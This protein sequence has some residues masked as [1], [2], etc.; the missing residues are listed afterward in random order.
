MSAADH[1][2]W[3]KANGHDLGA[4]TGTDTKALRAVHELWELYCYTRERTVLQAVALTARSMQASTRPLAKALIPMS[5]DW[6]DE[7][8]IWSLVVRT[9]LLDGAQ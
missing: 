3:L 7:D 4:L 5:M 6:S 1:L 2:K 9:G 8:P